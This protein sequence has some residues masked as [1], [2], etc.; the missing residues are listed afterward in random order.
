MLQLIWQRYTLFDILLICNE[1]ADLIHFHR[2]FKLPEN[3]KHSQFFVPSHIGVFVSC[4]QDT[5]IYWK[6]NNKRP[7]LC[8]SCCYCLFFMLLFWCECWCFSME[9]WANLSY[10]LSA[11]PTLV[12]VAEEG[13]R[14]RKPHTFARWSKVIKS[15]RCYPGGWKINLI[16][17]IFE[18][19]SQ[20]H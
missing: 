8:C 16:P 11:Y 18:I 20:K 2:K 10:W 19:L 12:V 5:S 1:S 3:H 14:R 13:S 17:P 15:V 9:L 7:D 4:F 6:T